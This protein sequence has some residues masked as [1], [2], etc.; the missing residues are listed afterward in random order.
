MRILSNKL[1]AG[2]VAA[3]FAATS[4]GFASWGSH[5][6]TER[7]T[8]VTFVEMVK[9]QN[10]DTLKAGTYRMEVAED[11][12][13]PNVSFYQD[14]KVVATVQAKAITEQTKNSDTEI[15]YNQQGEAHILTEIKPAGWEEALLFGSSSQ[16][17]ASSNTGGQ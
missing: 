2:L 17:G 1:F 8:N 3:L 7:A 16:G 15:D 13:T 12:Q 5:K 10:G 9:L 6:K 11:S 4:L 14:G